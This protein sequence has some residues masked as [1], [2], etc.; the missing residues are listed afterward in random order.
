MLILILALNPNSMMKNTT[1]A[2][3]SLLLSIII[4][5]CFPFPEEVKILDVTLFMQQSHQLY[6][7]IDT[8]LI[9]KDNQV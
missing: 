6:W 5:M 2:L 3:V 1:H 9:Y 8:G 7:I 4:D